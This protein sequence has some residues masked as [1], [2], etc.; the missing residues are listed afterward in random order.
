MMKLDDLIKEII[1]ESTNIERKAK[2]NEDGLMITTPDF[3]YIQKRLYNEIEIKFTTDSIIK[4][5][6]G[7]E[8]I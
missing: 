4:F 7:L 3:N 2:G 8:N 5:Y 1:G 6:D